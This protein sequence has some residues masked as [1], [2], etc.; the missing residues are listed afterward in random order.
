MENNITYHIDICVPEELSIRDIDLMSVFSNLIDNAIE[1]CSKVEV[2]NRYI[3]IKSAMI[4]NYLTIDITNSKSN[5]YIQDNDHFVTWKEDKKLHGYGLKII[6][7]IMEKYEGEIQCRDYGNYFNA[8]V[9]LKYK[10][11]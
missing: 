5:N 8:K 4:K 10:I 7:E 6:H 2:E 9:M 1:N 11:N 3:N